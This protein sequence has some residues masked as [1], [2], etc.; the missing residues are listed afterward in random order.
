MKDNVASSPVS[1]PIVSLLYPTCRSCSNSSSVLFFESVIR[2]K[3]PIDST[4]GR[5]FRMSAAI[6]RSLSVLRT[7]GFA[8]VRKTLC[9][10]FGRGNPC[11]LFVIMEAGL[12]RK[13]CTSNKSLS[14]SSMGVILN[15]KGRSLYSV[16]NLHL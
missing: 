8:P 9:I 12:L 11:S 6:S 4:D 7:N 14:I 15:L 1:T 5:Y 16:Q 2:A 3:Q 13:T 10:G